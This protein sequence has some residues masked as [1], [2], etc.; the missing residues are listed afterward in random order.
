[1]SHTC[2]QI[3]LTDGFVPWRTVPVI[4]FAHFMVTPICDKADHSQAVFSTTAAIVPIAT[5]VIGLVW[6]PVGVV[7]CRVCRAP[8]ER[9][10]RLCVSCIQVDRVNHV[11]WVQN[12]HVRVSRLPWWGNRPKLSMLNIMTGFKCP[13]IQQLEQ[14]A[15]TFNQPLNDVVFRFALNQ[16]QMSSMSQTSVASS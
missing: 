1:M 5:A 14:I 13:L 10:F 11:D 2:R 8:Q 12:G 9:S 15:G 3:H 6:R 7:Q 4:P 16:Y